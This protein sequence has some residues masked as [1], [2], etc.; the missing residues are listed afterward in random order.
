MK[1]AL[2]MEFPETWMSVSIASEIRQ[3]KS[4]NVIEA[5]VGIING[6]GSRFGDNMVL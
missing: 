2:E 5:E 1:E 3:D 4:S 6:S